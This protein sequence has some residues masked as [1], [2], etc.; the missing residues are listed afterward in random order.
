M[1]ARS[2]FALRQILRPGER[3]VRSVDFVDAC[4]RRHGG[5]FS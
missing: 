5:R 4:G 3:F 1:A 2:A